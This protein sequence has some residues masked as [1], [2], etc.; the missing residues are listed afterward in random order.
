MRRPDV[1]Y[2]VAGILSARTSAV[3]LRRLEVAGPESLFAPRRFRVPRCRLV[4]L[5]ETYFAGEKPLALG[6][7]LRNPAAK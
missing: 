5:L 2:V 3:F 6:R 4:S 7:A 1:R